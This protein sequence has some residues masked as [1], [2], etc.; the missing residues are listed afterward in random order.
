MTPTSS[1]QMAGAL[2]EQVP[3]RVIPLP[4]VADPISLGSDRRPHKMRRR[5]PAMAAVELRCVWA[6]SAIM[7]SLSWLSSVVL[8]GL[9]HCAFSHHSLDHSAAAQR[10]HIRGFDRPPTV[11]AAPCA[12]RFCMGGP[13]PPRSSSI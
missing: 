13:L 8:I 9:A 1:T 4:F 3:S 6:D 12:G 7:A 10:G 11:V 2:A 5:R